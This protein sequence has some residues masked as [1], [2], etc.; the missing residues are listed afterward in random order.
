MK[1]SRQ[2]LGQTDSTAASQFILHFRPFSNNYATVPPESE[3]NKN[4]WKCTSFKIKS[5]LPKKKD[6]MC[7][8][9]NAKKAKK[10]AKSSWSPT[11]VWTL[12]TNCDDVLHSSRTC[13]AA[14]A[15]FAVLCLLSLCSTC[16]PA[17]CVCCPSAVVEHQEV[18]LVTL[19]G[20]RETFAPHICISSRQIKKWWWCRI[21]HFAHDW[22]IIWM[23]LFFSLE[24]QPSWFPHTVWNVDSTAFIPHH[25]STFS[26][27]PQKLATF[28]MLVNL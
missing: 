25:T 13:V 12:S 22:L 7:F 6:K 2:R 11:L 9:W 27:C 16:S 18:S 8:I 19:Y 17:R 26:L 15:S 4:K 20:E 10:R 14:A 24:I 3:V 1:G 23:F 28:W 21:D 5:N